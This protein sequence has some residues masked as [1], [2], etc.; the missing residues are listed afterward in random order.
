MSQPFVS[1]P[2]KL[3]AAV[4]CAAI[5]VLSFPPSEAREP[6]APWSARPDVVE[7]FESRRGQFNYHEAK[8]PSYTLPDALV[9][10][11]GSKISTADAW[12]KTRRAELMELFR[13]HVYGHRPEIEYSV[14]FKQ[15]DVSENAFDRT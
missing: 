10:S 1:V 11:N 14:Q 9:A 3:S 2:L 5:I 7:K 8:V 12:R 15:T 4:L 6:W 13:S